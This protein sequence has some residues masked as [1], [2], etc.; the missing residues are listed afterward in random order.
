MY[1]LSRVDYRLS[2]V[3][4][5]CAKSI[6]HLQVITYHH[7]PLVNMNGHPLEKLGKHKIY[8]KLA[9]Q[10]DYYMVSSVSNSL[11]PPKARLSDYYATFCF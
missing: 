5:R 9:K 6:Q 1:N 7:L 8:V 3:L 10:S 2:L 4:S 11:C